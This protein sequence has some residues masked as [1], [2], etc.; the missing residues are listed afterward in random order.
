MGL[1]ITGLD[2]GGNALG[3]EVGQAGAQGTACGGLAGAAGAAQ[4]TGHVVGGDGNVGSRKEHVALLAALLH[5]HEECIKPSH[6]NGVK[7]PHTTFH[8]DETDF[9]AQ[10]CQSAR[11]SDR[12]T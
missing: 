8:S 11:P 7:F 5:T 3:L 4:H 6:L 12:V 1:T 9:G 10:N 2:V